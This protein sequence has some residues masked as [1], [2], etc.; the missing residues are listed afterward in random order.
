M[1]IRRLAAILLAV[2][3]IIVLYIYVIFDPSGSEW[4][5]KCPLYAITGFKCPGCGSQRAI[6]ALLNGDLATAFKMNG[7]LV[8]SI[9]FILLLI[10]SEITRKKHPELYV[11]VHNIYVIY[12]VLA[13]VIIWWITRNI[14]GI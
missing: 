12:A 10:Y 2:S 11:R 4:F 13:I 1:G 7:L 5:P 6:H 3:A 8:M 14:I 9:P